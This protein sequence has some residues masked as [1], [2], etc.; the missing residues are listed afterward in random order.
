MSASQ[1]Q[2][3]EKQTPPDKSTVVLLLST[4][5]D[6]TWRMFVPIIVGLLVGAKVDSL[7][8]IQPWAT[9]AGLLIGVAVT[10]LLIRLQFRNIDK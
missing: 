10:T 6:T 7:W 3:D 9:A 8:Q 1:N 4:I 2:R 5:G